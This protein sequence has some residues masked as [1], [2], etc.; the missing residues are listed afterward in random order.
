M[1][2]AD[3]AH[4]VVPTADQVDQSC[5]SLAV[6]PGSSD[7]E[8]NRPGLSPATPSRRSCG[9]LAVLP[10]N[11][12]TDTQSPKRWADLSDDATDVDSES[13]EH[14]LLERMRET[15]PQVPRGVPRRA[16]R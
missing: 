7:V 1:P 4:E 3:H 13:T 6:L 12:T 9:D 8:I 11:C 14:L 15:M 10:S 2:T 5:G 16:A